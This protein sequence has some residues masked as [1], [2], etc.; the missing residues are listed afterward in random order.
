MKAGQL[1]ALL[2]EVPEDTDVRVM[3]EDGDG[4]M[5]EREYSAAPRYETQ[6]A[7]T[8]T[9]FSI[10]IAYNERF[11]KT[12]ECE[13]SDEPSAPS[14]SGIDMGPLTVIE[15]CE[16]FKSDDASF[17]YKEYRY[18]EGHRPD[19]VWNQRRLI[20]GIHLDPVL[21]EGFDSYPNENRPSQETA[22]W[23][24]VPF[25]VSSVGVK[26]DAVRTSF[27][28]RMLDGGAWDR[29]TWH[30]D[31]DNIDAALRLAKALK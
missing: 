26:D 17:E 24:D 14:S 31:H 6:H 2:Q 15:A 12:E 23:W 3:T 28:V 5:F 4:F 18:L 30:G 1:I 7:E 11:D 13:D 20:Q 29:S 21:P 9:R 27:T 25:I 10:D 22:D 16:P 19:S 8:P